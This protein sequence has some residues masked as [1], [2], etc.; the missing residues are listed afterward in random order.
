MSRCIRLIG[1]DGTSVE[2][3][4][5]SR[6]RPTARSLFAA[7]GGR[8]H[9]DSIGGDHLADDVAKGSQS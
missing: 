6:R 9:D 5:H 3:G 7:T 1:V 8:A 2:M 4:D